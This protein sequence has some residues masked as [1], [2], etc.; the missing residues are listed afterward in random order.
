MMSCNNGTANSTDNTPAPP[1]TPAISFSIVSVQPH[2]TSFFT[3]GFEF[4]NNTLL[5][6]TGLNGKSRLVQTD[7]K[8]GKILKQI[9][10]DPKFFGEGITVL[11][12]T[13]YQL[14][15][16]EHTVH[17]YDAKT[18]KKI[19][20]L[21]FNT[22]GW[23]L[24]ND[25]KNL[26]A[27]DGSSNLY[28]YEPSTFRLL[29]TQGVMENGSPVVNINELE[30]IDGFIYANQWQYNDILKINPNTG[31]VVAKMDLSDL[32]NKVKA[33]DPQAE[34]LNGIAYNHA[35]NKFYITGKLWPDIYEL[36]FQH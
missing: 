9:N 16:Q 10:L 7:P 14:T 29:H 30:Y 26:I 25:G 1:A 15:W 17:V 12:D 31:E 34:F 19:K 3:E 32:V 18:F 27:S 35:T 22:E 4:Y 36:Q 11:H 21:S 13:L 6:S 33:K 2:D 24:T 20:E 8:T 23:G 28:F 5:E